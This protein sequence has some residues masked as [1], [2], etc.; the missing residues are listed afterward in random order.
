MQIAHNT[1]TN[2]L[3]AYSLAWKIL[4]LIYPPVCIRCGKLGFRCCP[5]CWATKATYDG[6]ICTICGQPLTHP[7]LCPDCTA[8]PPLLEKI[9][10]L[11]EYVG[12]L[13]DLILGLKYHRNIGLA[14]FVIPDLVRL[15]AASQFQ[16]DILVPVPL[17]KTRQ[18]ERGYNQVTVWGKLL[19]ATI[20]TPMLTSALYRHQTTISQVD[21]PVEKRWENVRGVFSAVEEWVIG[22]NILLL[23]DVITTGATLAECAKVLKEAGANRVSALTIARS[24]P[25][26][27]KNQGGMYV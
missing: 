15:M 12:V 26:K 23:D 25:K 18:R 24:S 22:K 2:W 21:L 6:N 7:S 1:H 27:D 4:D 3:K 14:E 8:V 20:G 10:S 9:R 5:D 13:S 11:G 16:F 17:S 19:S